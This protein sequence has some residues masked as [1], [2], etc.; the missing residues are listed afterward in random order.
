[1]KLSGREKY[2]IYAAAC[3]IGFFVIIK[4]IVFPIIDNQELLT[5]TIRMKTKM[6]EEILALKSEYD[7]IKKQGE[8]SR[9]RFTKREKGFTL[10]SFL[11]N[12]SGQAGIK[13][14][15]TYMKPSTSSGK[16]GQQK[17]SAVEMRLQAVTLNHLTSY[18]YMIEASEN[19][20]NIKRLSISKTGSQEDLLDVVLQVET[21]IS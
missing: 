13:D 12:L 15:I 18:L 8:L 1:M 10:F 5:R 9:V 6:L 14:N 19:M 3:F 21:Y 4:F 2:S 11:D 20:V 7:D 16:N 17:I